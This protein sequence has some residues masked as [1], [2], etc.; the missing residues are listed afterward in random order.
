MK[1]LLLI[2]IILFTS[3]NAFGDEIT[4]DDQN[5]AIGYLLEMTE[6]NWSINNALRI[7]VGNL[8]LGML[9]IIPLLD[10]EPLDRKRALNVCYTILDTLE[11]A[12]AR[13]KAN[14]N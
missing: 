6:Y 8:V 4:E 14:E 11:I 12:Y 10:L 2:L 7:Q 9:A 1:K 5:S 3:L 13:V